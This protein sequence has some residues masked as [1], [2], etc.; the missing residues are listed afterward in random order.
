VLTAQVVARV[1]VRVGQDFRDLL[2]PEAKLAVEED[3]PQSAQVVQR[4]LAVPGRGPGAG[5]EQA[6]PVVV[7]QRP[8]RDPG[9]PGYR[10]HRVR[11]VCHIAYCGA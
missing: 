4:V 11:V 6:Q 8:H 1:L 9:H 5:H 7:V 10:A 2:Q 3:L